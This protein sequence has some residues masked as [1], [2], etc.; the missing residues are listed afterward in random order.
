MPSNPESLPTKHDRT[1]TL[2]SGVSI[3]AEG[4]RM[5]RR[6]SFVAALI[7]A[8]CAA[9]LTLFA[10][11]ASAGATAGF[12]KFDT[13][14]QGSWQ[15]KYGTDGYAIANVTPQKLPGYASTFSPQNQLSYTWNSSTS[16]PRA[17]QVPGGSGGIASTWY[18]TG[19][20][21]FTV[22]FTDGNTHQLALYAVDWDTQGRS[23]TVTILDGSTNAQLDVRT[24][25]NFTNGTY[26]IWNISGSVKINVA[27]TGGPNGVISG[28]FFD[29]PGGVVN[30]EAVTITPP[31]VNLSANGTQTFSATVSNATNQNVT[32]SILSVSPSNAATGSISS[33]GLYTAPGTATISTAQVTIQA[34]SADQT[35]SS[36][37]SVN[38]TAVNSS[39]NFV[40]VDTATE[41]SWQ[42]NYGSD[43]YALAG[44]TESIPPYAT[45]AVASQLDYT[46]VPDSS[47]PRA[48]QMPGNTGRIAASWYSIHDAIPPTF[49]FDVNFTDGLSHQLALYALD[50]D[51]QGRVETISILDA[52]SQTQL[53]SRSIS[54]FTSGTYLIWNVTG[55]VKI[56]FTL[57]VGPNSVISGV[58]F[59]GSA[60]SSGGGGGSSVSVSVSPATVTLGRGQT[61]QFNSTVTG[62]TNTGVTWSVS[63]SSGAGTISQS[64]FYQA[65][66]PV[67]SNQKVTVTALSQQDN[68]T[69]GTATVNLT[70]GGVANYV[71]TDTSTEGSWKGI[72]GSDGYAMAGLTFGPPNYA[73]F[74]VQGEANW[75]YAANTTDPRA[76]Q[77]PTGSGGIASV[78]YQSTFSL[79]VN[80]TDNQL[81]EVALYAVDWDNGGRSEM[82]QIVDGVSGSVLDTRTLTNFTNGVYLVWNISGK[83]VINISQSSG[84]NAVVNGVFFGAGSSLSVSVTPRATSLSANQSQ[85][86]SASVTGPNQSVTWSISPATGAGTITAGGVY[87]A[88]SSIASAQTVTV[89]ATATSGAT[90]TATISLT[91]GANASFT[92]S[93][94]TTQGNWKQAYGTAGYCLAGDDCIPPSFATYAVSN[95]NGE[96][97]WTTAT[98]DPRALQASSFSGRIAG[99]WYK[100]HDSFVLDVN[101][102]DQNSHPFELYLLDWDS[103]NRAESISILD[104]SSG[105]LLDTRTVSSFSNGV[106]EK[107]NITGHVTINV[108]VTSGAN[109][110]ISGA[111]FQ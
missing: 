106:Y 20:F 56:N 86:F 41:G 62:A 49:S 7:F 90:G 89:T 13:S 43:G 68:A 64:G 71:A 93:D 21:G 108:T 63:P 19:V 17:L 103:Q 92:G 70:T 67:T 38:L 34:V 54:S 47:D 14:T 53:D 84:P 23:E 79:D 39:A 6:L 69:T 30:P 1:R 76:P 3:R 87:T 75:T 28:A 99:A 48:L 61:T 50:W 110:V 8:A 102:T 32:W 37:A 26:A 4:T 101:F 12:V 55:H 88:P 9:Q 15:G 91:A 27:F 111:F 33:S 46:W 66:T 51:V 104:A 100:N 98:S 85:A 11:P 77:L 44:S 40:K 36:T 45:F 109:A 24:I 96:W 107:W 29:T 72:Y 16:D 52:A 22:N 5:Y 82:V 25:S 80:I 83:V 81:H 60:G 57:N 74:Q 59:G 58:F 2:S 73:T 78:W 97:T 65:P 94:A 105:Q 10:V 35:A 42:G 18:S 95:E 31:S